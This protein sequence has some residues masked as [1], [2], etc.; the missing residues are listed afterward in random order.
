MRWNVFLVAAR[1]ITYPS[2][3]V[4]NTRF[5]PTL[6]VYK[7]TRFFLP[8][9]GKNICLDG[10]LV[11]LENNNGH[12]TQLSAEEPPLFRALLASLREEVLGFFPGIGPEELES[13]NV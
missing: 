3:S 2:L 4:L 5:L 12:L 9:S 8:D 13:V 7:N 1:V 10:F 6:F 11:V